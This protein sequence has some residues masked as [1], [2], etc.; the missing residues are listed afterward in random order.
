MATLQDYKIYKWGEVAQIENYPYGFSKRCTLK[1]WVEDTKRGARLTTT[2]TWNGKENAPKSSTCGYYD[3]AFLL[4]KEGFLYVASVSRDFKTLT[5]NRYHGEGEKVIIELTEPE[6]ALIPEEVLKNYSLKIKV[7]E[8]LNKSFSSA[9]DQ[10]QEILKNMTDDQIRAR[11]KTASAWVIGGGGYYSKDGFYKHEGGI[12]YGNGR[13]YKPFVSVSLCV[14]LEGTNFILF[15]N[16]FNVE[17][18]EGERLTAKLKAT[19]EAKAREQLKTW[20]SSLPDEDIK[21]IR[22]G[23]TGIN[24][25]IGNTTQL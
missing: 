22:D 8:H 23:A 19:C 12:N 6:R 17:I 16:S 4:T 7:Q 24:I 18:E 14:L 3:N 11:I 15:P 10:R 5:I 2:T 21:V 9:H 13:E 20:L 1:A 25:S